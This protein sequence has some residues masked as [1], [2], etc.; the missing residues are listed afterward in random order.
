MEVTRTC[1]KC[2]ELNAINEDALDTNRDSGVEMW[3]ECW[4]CREHFRLNKPGE[5]GEGD[6][7][8]AVSTP[9]ASPYLFHM[10]R[11]VR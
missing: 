1:P 5:G 10:W 3:G 6:A 8:A 4:K 9:I 2:R 11:P 7:V